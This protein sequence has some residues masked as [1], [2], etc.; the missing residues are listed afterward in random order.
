MYLTLPCLLSSSLLPLV[1][2]G[3][4]EHAPASPALGSARAALETV[5]GPEIGFGDPLPGFA[6]E[7]QWRPAVAFGGG[8]YF[9]VW[10]DHRNGRDRI[11]GSRVMPDGTLV[12]PYGRHLADGREPSIASDG[13]TFL[14]AYEGS[15]LMPTGVAS[16]VRVMRVDPAGVVLDPGGIL[17]ADDDTIQAKVASDGHGFFVVWD[18]ACSSSTCEVRAARVAGGGAVLD[19]G[20]FLVAS[21]PKGP[22]LAAPIVASDGTEYL[23]VW[24][25]GELRARRFSAS[26][27]PLD[28]TH[29][30]LVA[31]PDAWDPALLHDGTNYV[32]GWATGTGVRALRISSSGAVIDPSP[33][34]VAIDPSSYPGSLVAARD[35]VNTLFAWGDSNGVEASFLRIGRLSPAGIPLDPPTGIALGKNV[36][37]IALASSGAEALALWTQRSH[38]FWEVTS[39][40]IVGTRIDPSGAALDEPRI[41]VS[42]SANQQSQ[43]AVA[44]DGTNH[45]VVWTDDR[46]FEQGTQWFDIHAAR[47]SPDGTLLDPQSIP[48]F[49]GD[50]MQKQPRAFFDG[51]NTLVVWEGEESFPPEEPLVG[52]AARL[53]PGGEIL[54]A[55]PIPLPASSDAASDGAGLLFVGASA[56]KLH[57]FRVGQDGVVSPVIDLSAAPTEWLGHTPAISF[58]GTNFFV[59]WSS[60]AGIHGGRLTPA[61]EPLDPGGVLVAPAAPGM[62]TESPDVVFTGTHHVVSWQE[63]VAPRL[64][65]LRAAR[66]TPDGMV[67]DPPGLVIGENLP[68]GACAGVAYSAFGAIEG[69]CPSLVAV[70][71]RALVA[72]RAFTDPTD[73]AAIDLVA[74]TIEADGTVT[75]KV[76]LSAEPTWVEGVPAIAAENGNKALVAYARFVPGEPFSANRVFGRFV[77]LDGAGGSGGGSGSGSGSGGAGGASSSSGAGGLGG[78]GE[79]PVNGGEG[80]D[81][82][83]TPGETKPLLPFG[84]AASLLLLARLRRTMRRSAHLVR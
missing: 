7:L 23:V 65:N 68:F 4:G 50:W 67:V 81:C 44:F 66:V 11:F 79:P 77:E 10:Q 71:S 36:D 75:P 35:G 49:A 80:C 78:A 56:G 37:G 76:P 26:G 73:P 25:D 33:I 15:T 16:S 45:V 27:A 17:V 1:L 55:A 43:P 14:L 72:F 6:A 32:F 42:Q 29:T 3:C 40:D 46:D 28:P 52:R 74:R 59:T 19:P 70:G 82:R 9:A 2:V 31:G 48:V 47:L 21:V 54:D 64:A 24:R 20:G 62:P 18:K 57:A 30:V 5:V 38:S 51:Q 12:D 63:V 34:E 60:A 13:T 8:A 61:G 83:V 84:A 39:G 22:H 53:S 69:T 58:D 41:V